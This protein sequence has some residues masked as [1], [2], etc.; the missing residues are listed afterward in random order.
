MSPRW[1]K[2]LERMTSFKQN[3]RISHYISNL[4]GT[5]LEEAWIQIS[6]SR[7]GFLRQGCY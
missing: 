2:E 4:G 1:E 3:R 6:G 7:P 5:I